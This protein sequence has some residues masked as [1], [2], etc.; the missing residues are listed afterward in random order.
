MKHL[1]GRVL[2]LVRK[3]APVPE[4]ALSSR[5]REGSLGSVR[6]ASRGW[7]VKGV[8][9]KRAEIDASSRHEI[10]IGVVD[11]CFGL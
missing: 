11:A 3:D 10:L 9:Q 5:T 2:H 4:P 7:R 1:D 6:C 8:K